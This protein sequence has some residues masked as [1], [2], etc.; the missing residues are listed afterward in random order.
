MFSM[1]SELNPRAR[2]PDTRIPQLMQPCSL[3]FYDTNQTVV[4]LLAFCRK[5]KINACL[6]FL[7][8]INL[9]RQYAN[10]AKESIRRA[11]CIS[12]KNDPKRQSTFLAK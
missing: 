5:E 4:K 10:I 11:M 9:E 3:Q 6:N 7:Q 2:I 12:V 8:L 1:C